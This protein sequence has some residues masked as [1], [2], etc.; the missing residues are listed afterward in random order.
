[1]NTLDMLP[2]QFE[3]LDAA[4]R[5]MRINHLKQRAK[6]LL[7]SIQRRSGEMDCGAALADHI[8]P[9]LSRMERKF[10]DVMDE[11]ARLDP[12]APSQ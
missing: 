8:R 11:L 5:A 6:R 3:K 9:D 1:M 2:E 10:S 7:L 4:G 12:E